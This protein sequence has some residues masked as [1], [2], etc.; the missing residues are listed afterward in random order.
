MHDL[1]SNQNG[2]IEF[3]CS[4]QPAWHGLGQNVAEAQT[5]REASKLANLEWTISKLQLINPR[6]GVLIPSFALV[7]DDD[8]R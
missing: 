5:W 1:S 3:F 7:R 2:Q 6:T 4:G 8:G